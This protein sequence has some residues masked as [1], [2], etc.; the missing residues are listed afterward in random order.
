MRMPGPKR[1]SALLIRTTEPNSEN[2][3][4]ENLR[5][6]PWYLTPEVWRLKTGAYLPYPLRLPSLR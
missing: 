3:K 2:V 5:P 4:P 1:G 6:E